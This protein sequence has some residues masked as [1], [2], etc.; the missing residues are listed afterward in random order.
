MNFEAVPETCSDDVPAIIG[1][2]SLVQTAYQQGD[3]QGIWRRL[4][5]RVEA[6]PCD[7]AA[8]MDMS[9]ILQVSGHREKGLGLQRSAVRESRCYRRVHGRGTGL[10]SSHSSRKAT[11]G[12]TYPS[13]FFSKV[14]I[15]VC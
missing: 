3:L 14:P 1:M 11:S 12:P 6:N 15:S 8:L 7:A 4:L 10:K 9:V 5:S 2:A 13:T